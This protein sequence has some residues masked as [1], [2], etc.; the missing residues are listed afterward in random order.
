MRSM[1]FPGS[2]HEASK[3]PLEVLIMERSKVLQSENTSLRVERDRATQDLSRCKK[4]LADKTTEVERQTQLIQQL[5]DHV[6]QLQELSKR[7][8]A[9]GRSSADI[10]TEA[11]DVAQVLRSSSSASLTREASP[12]LT[13]G[14]ASKAAL[15]PIVQAQRERFK[16]RNEELE[17]EQARQIDHISLLQSEVQDLRDDK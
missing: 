10:L 13:D 1:E 3:K 8:E 5:E 4:E 9:E 16:Q 6:E 7:G 14:Q 11:L 17:A 15:L 2:E 12:D